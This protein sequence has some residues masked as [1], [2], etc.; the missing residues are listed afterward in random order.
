MKSKNLNRTR[1]NT[2]ILIIL[3]ITIFSSCNHKKSIQ[4]DFKNPNAVE[5]DKQIVVVSRKI[6]EERIETNLENLFPVPSS[7]FQTLP[8]QYDDLNGDGKW[9]EIAFLTS[10]NPEEKKS[11]EFALVNDYNQTEDF[12]SS[13]NIHFGVKPAENKPAQPVEHYVLEGNNLPSDDEFYPFQMDGPAWENDKVGFRLYFDGRNAKDIFAK[14]QPDLVLENVGLDSLGNPVDN[15]HVLEDWG[16]DVLQVGNSLGAGGLAMLKNDSLHR[17]GIIRGA[18]QNVVDSTV[19]ELINPGP[20]RGIFSLTYYGWQVG[21]EKI[22]LKEIISINTGEY[23]YHSR[24]ILFG[25]DKKTTL[26]TGMANLNND[27]P[28]QVIETDSQLY[29]LTHD[30]Q[31]Y[32][33]EY[34]M[35]MAL[36]AEKSTDTGYNQATDSG[37]GVVSSYYIS[38]QL[39]P[40]QEWEYTFY[41]FCEL[42]DPKF[43]NHEYFKNYIQKELEKKDIEIQLKKQ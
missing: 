21:N 33:K 31:T 35:G 4:I 17:L 27:N 26:V 19:F 16:R 43:R 22:D 11:I 28:L 37:P 34:F 15:Y 25:S 24:V 1:T 41:A 32:E 29:L 9:D 36:S 5:M 39:Q 23:C 8:V 12:K 10:F 13:T 18:A 3:V 14:R 30:K 7:R 2:L 20:V 42:A 6:F 40:N 38:Q